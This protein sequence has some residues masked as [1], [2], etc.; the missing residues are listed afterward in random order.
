MGALRHPEAQARP[1]DG[2]LIGNGSRWCAACDRPHGALFE[3]PSYSP[4]IMAAIQAHEP[5]PLPEG[6]YGSGAAQVLA[7]FVRPHR[8]AYGSHNK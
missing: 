8:V 4:E 7:P 3:C 5:A 2:E 1:S 6:A